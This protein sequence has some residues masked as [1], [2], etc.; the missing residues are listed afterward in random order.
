LHAVAAQ[1][2][3]GLGRSAAADAQ[4]AKAVQ[5]NRNAMRLNPVAQPVQPE[6]L[7]ML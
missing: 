6:L 4:R 2:N 5:M 3:A 7:S 1:I